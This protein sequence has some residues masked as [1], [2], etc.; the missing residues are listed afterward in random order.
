MSQLEKVGSR[1]KMAETRHESTMA[2]YGG[3]VVRTKDL[4]GSCN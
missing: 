4:A 3:G 1:S 2:K